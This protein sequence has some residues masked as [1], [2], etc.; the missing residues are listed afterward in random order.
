MLPCGPAS[1]LIQLEIG[2]SRASEIQGH[3]TT[4]R[5]DSFLGLQSQMTRGRGR[6]GRAANEREF[7]C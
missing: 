7:A 5:R 1:I 3:P 2:I 6:K 4:L